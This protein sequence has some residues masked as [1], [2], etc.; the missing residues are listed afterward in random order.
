MAN[1]NTEINLD[2]LFSVIEEEIRRQFP[3]FLS[4]EFDREEASAPPAAP[5]CILEMTEAEKYQDQDPGTEQLAMTCRFEARL[6]IAFNQPRAKSEVRKLALAFAAW[7]HLRRWGMQGQ[8][9][10]PAEIIGAYRDDFSPVL[11]KYEAWRVEWT[12]EI[13]IGQ[14]VW[15][16]EG[17]PPA[18]YIRLDPA[19]D[20]RIYT[21][22]EIMDGKH[23]PIDEYV[24][25]AQLLDGS[26]S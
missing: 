24:P 14:S 26:A 21:Q 10:G 22:P 18:A 25:L 6:L 1:A 23:H 17:T 5:A 13:H 20:P 15:T 11:D 12:Q 9:T 2:A 4:V 8:P 3:D 16:D 7:M 19:A